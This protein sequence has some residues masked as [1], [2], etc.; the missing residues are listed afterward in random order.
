[1]DHKTTFY[2]CQ[3]DSED[4]KYYLQIVQ[5]WIT[6]IYNIK[7]EIVKNLWLTKKFLFLFI[8]FSERF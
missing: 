2:E 6:V 3:M 4:G 1:M 7:W 8:F 5:K